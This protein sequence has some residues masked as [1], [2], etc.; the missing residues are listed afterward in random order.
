M[1]DVSKIIA[2]GTSKSCALDPLTTSIV[3]QFLPELLLF[4][5]AVCN[6]SCNFSALLIRFLDYSAL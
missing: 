4:V 6:L 2:S 1:E 5:T 3:K